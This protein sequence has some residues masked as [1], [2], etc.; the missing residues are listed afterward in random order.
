LQ[1]LQD[2]YIDGD[3]DK[4]EY[5][6][7][8]TR[9]ENIHS[10][11]KDKEKED[12][13]EKEVFELY[14]NAI[15]KVKNIEKQHIEGDID[16]KRRIIGSIFPNNFQFE[17]IKVRTADLNPIPMKI[18]SFNGASRGKKNGTSLKNRLVP[19]REPIDFFS[20]QVLEFLEN[21]VEKMP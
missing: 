16:T 15:D 8:K 18:T 7:A 12:I 4:T 21:L 3:I 9:Y 20:N 14:K 11:L 2:I 5:Q 10:E 6:I 17:N 19:Y 13:N 1:R